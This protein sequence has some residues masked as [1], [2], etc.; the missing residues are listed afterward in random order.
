MRLKWTDEIREKMKARLAEIGGSTVDTHIK[1]IQEVF[2]NAIV[3]GSMYC[4]TAPTNTGKTTL[5][6]AIAKNLARQGKRT[7]FITKEQS[8]EQM[9]KKIGLEESIPNL[10]ISD[11]LDDILHAGLEYENPEYVIYDYIGADLKLGKWDE[12]ITFADKLAE[13]CKSVNCVLFT[14]CQATP[15]LAI[16]YEENPLDPSLSTPMYVAYSKGITN[17]ATGSAYLLKNGALINFKNRYGERDRRS[18]VKIDFVHCEVTG[19]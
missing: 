9:A 10:T 13:Y 14:A 2:D 11:D 12:I 7:V 3:K 16:K 4:F 6:L 17:K 5:L 15:E 8:I 19:V 18:S 1:F